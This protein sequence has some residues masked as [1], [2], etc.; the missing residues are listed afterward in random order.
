ML[1]NG[2]CS[3]LLRYSTAS[4]LAAASP[5]GH[6]AQGLPIN[7]AARIRANGS[8]GIRWHNQLKV[9]QRSCSSTVTSYADAVKGSCNSSV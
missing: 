9:G 7:L 1:R 6:A 8:V 3:C 2:K 4:Q 5:I